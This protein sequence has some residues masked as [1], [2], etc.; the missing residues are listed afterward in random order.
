MDGR[1]EIGLNGEK[2]P[3]ED[4]LAICGELAAIV[5][6]INRY[7]LKASEEGYGVV[8]KLAPDSPVSR[9][10][11]EL[12]LKTDKSDSYKKAVVEFLNEGLS[13]ILARSMTVRNR[14][15][16][17][18]LLS[19]LSELATE[20]QS[21]MQNNAFPTPVFDHD[22]L[23]EIIVMIRN[24]KKIISKKL[25]PVINAG[26]QEVTIGSRGKIAMKDIE[27]EKIPNQFRSKG[28]F[29]LSQVHL[30]KDAAWKAEINKSTVAI[31]ITDKSW[32]DKF[33]SREE[34]LHHGDAIWADFTVT[35][36]GRGNVMHYLTNIISVDIVKTLEQLEMDF[37]LSQV[38]V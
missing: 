1:I 9:I 13:L 7:L 17:E 22:K 38:A 23:C 32:L 31:Q 2:L 18:Q 26:R 3:P 25:S 35:D 29:I 16:V 12:A 30:Q 15:D 5:G 11:I 37:H 14:K 8:H 19:G 20:F 34:S 33:M 28:L 4:V 10:I 24:I 6:E 21:T 27:T 36:D